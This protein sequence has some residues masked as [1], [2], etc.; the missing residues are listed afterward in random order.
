[1]IDYVWKCWNTTKI[2]KIMIRYINI[3]RISCR[4]R[5]WCQ[6]PSKICQKSQNHAE[7][8]KFRFDPMNLNI[9]SRRFQ[10]SQSQY[11]KLAPN[12]EKPM[13][14]KF[15]LFYIGFFSILVPV[16]LEAKT[17]QTL[18]KLFQKTFGEVSPGAVLKTN[19]LCII[20]KIFWSSIL[21]RVRA[22]FLEMC[23][24]FFELPGLLR[25]CFRLLLL[26]GLRPTR[27]PRSWLGFRRSW[28]ILQPNC[29]QLT[30]KLRLFSNI[31]FFYIIK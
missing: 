28:Q 11:E 24:W 6:N 17:M 8:T 23:S 15:H 31:A 14:S 7:I 30:L 26:G 10:K 29:H 9:F 3:Y 19:L 2:H 25:T 13:I 18:K 21:G 27:P 5:F 4:S 20:F 16:I 1:M 22:R 12:V